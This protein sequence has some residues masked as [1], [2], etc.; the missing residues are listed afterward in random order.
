[1]LQ[2]IECAH[3]LKGRI[4]KW[5]PVAVVNLAGLRM[6]FRDLDAGFRDVN[7]MCAKTL[8]FESL[9]NLSNAAADI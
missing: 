9:D 7:S 2:H 6:G 3:G 1:M 4:G 5:N 8:F